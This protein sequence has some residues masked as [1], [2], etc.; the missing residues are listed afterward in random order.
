MIAETRNDEV[1]AW[2]LNRDVAK[3][4]AE[5]G[6]G[7]P[8]EIVRAEMQRMIEEIDREIATLMEEEK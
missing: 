6:P 8:H 5:T 3:A 2:L 7:V 4:R 1:E